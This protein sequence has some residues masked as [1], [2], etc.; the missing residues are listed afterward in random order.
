[1]IVLCV[2]FRSSLSVLF[3]SSAFDTLEPFFNIQGHDIDGVFIRRY[4]HDAHSGPGFCL[5]RF[6]IVVPLSAVIEDAAFVFDRDF[7]E[8]PWPDTHGDFRSLADQG[9]GC[10]RL[11]AVVLERSE[12]QTVDAKG[13]DQSEQRRHCRP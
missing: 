9:I 13:C 4:G 12:H 5:S 10:Q 11:S 2:L 3:A 6:G 1:M 8:G 7:A